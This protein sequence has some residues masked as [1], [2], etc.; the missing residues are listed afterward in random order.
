MVPDDSPLRRYLVR[1]IQTPWHCWRYHT[2]CHG[3]LYHHVRYGDYFTREEM[4]FTWTDEL[5]ESAI[6]RWNADERPQTIADSLGVSR[7]S[8]KAKM[9]RLRKSGANIK[10][11]ANQR[12]SPV[13]RVDKG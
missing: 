12:P 6:K 11:N 7:K 4:K 8:L 3:C 5:V 13:H 9:D 1:H 2:L 10:L